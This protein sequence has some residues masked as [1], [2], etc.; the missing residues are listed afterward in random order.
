MKALFFI[1][2][3]LPFTAFCQTDS[4][5]IKLNQYKSWRDAGVISEEEYGQLKARLL[6]IP[7]STKDEPS[8]KKQIDTAALKN[9][10]QKS[11]SNTTGGIVMMSLGGGFLIGTTVYRVKGPTSGYQSNIDYKIVVGS[12][13]A[14]G[15]VS[16]IIGGILLGVGVHNRVLYNEGKKNLA[17]VLDK[18]KVGLAFN[19]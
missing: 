19:F 6:Q 5:T 14:V 18:D 15:S 13:Y 10:L 3:L 4:T 2:L 11:K 1:L 12:G 17:L 7:L 8:T 16:M 9:L